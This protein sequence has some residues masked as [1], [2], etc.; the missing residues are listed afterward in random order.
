[1]KKIFVVVLGIVFQQL[2]FSQSE[3]P[4]STAIQKPDTLA[5]RGV[6]WLAYPYIFY[7]PE[8]SLAFG[9]GGIIYFKLYDD[10]KAKSS[11]I[12]PSFYYTVNGQYDV[13]II[14][15]IYLMEDRL[16]I[17]SK[18]NYSSYFDRYYG[19]GNQ[20]AEIENDQY[21]QDNIQAQIK[22]QPKLFDDR[23]N[24]GINYEIRNMSVADT[25]GNPYLESDSTIIG[26][27]GG[28]TSGLGLAVSWD[29]RDNNFFPSSGGYYEAYASNFFEFLGSDFDYNKT[30]IDLRHY[31]NPT[32]SHVIA[33]QAYLLSEGGTPPFYDLG[34]LGGSKLMR[35]TIMGRYRDKT[36]YVIQSEYRMPQLVWRFGLILFAGFGDVAPSVGRITISTVKPTYGFGIRFRFDELEKVDIRMD[37]GFGKGSNGIYFDINQAF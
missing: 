15:E 16:K 24:L 10:P 17:W 19:I 8:T 29:T 31:W 32:L 11:S 20:T 22:L 3:K 6:D 1:M 14:P 9:G 36:Y 37:V 2:L 18:F 7:S 12:T 25:K 23:L 34:L 13:T 33:L 4:D 28:L 30:V 27:E 26:R 21:L 5:V 35:G